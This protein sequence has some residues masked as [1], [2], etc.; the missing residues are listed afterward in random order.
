[1]KWILLKALPVVLVVLFSS[2]VL[3][4]FN[5]SVAIQSTPTGGG[6]VNCTTGKS[7]GPC[8]ASLSSGDSVT[9][10]AHATQ[11]WDFLHWEGACQSAGKL[12]TCTLVMT[13]NKVATA[14]FGQPTITISKAGDATGLVVSQ[15]FPTGKIDC[16]STCTIRLP[17]GTSVQLTA[18]TNAGLFDKWTGCPAPHDEGCDLVLGVPITIT[19]AFRRPQ[20]SVHVEMDGSG[21]G[22]VVSNPTG[23]NCGQ[24][25]VQ[26][27]PMNQGVDLTATPGPKT[28]FLEFSN[29]HGPN[30]NLTCGNSPTCHL[31]TSGDMNLI[32]R[33]TQLL[34]ITVEVKGTGSVTALGYEQFNCSAST[35]NS[36]ILQV[37][38]TRSQVPQTTNPWQLVL[39]ANPPAGVQFTGWGGDCA[40]S[41]GVQCAVS[42]DNHKVT[43]NFTP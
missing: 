28:L 37:P 19:A 34:E 29:P 5:L 42:F 12:P 26:S 9:L 1:M 38:K 24:D 3:A 18:S 41:T 43:A 25:C 10:N 30:I 17:K 33:F 7:T 21:T 8:P 32:A 11:G 35:P 16:G 6:S 14:V 40:G 39:Q 4:A 13:G 36:C 20:I 27:F 15:N 23:I 31:V 22:S 2:V